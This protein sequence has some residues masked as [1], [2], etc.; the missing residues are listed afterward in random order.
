MSVAC[1]KSLSTVAVDNGRDRICR[2]ANM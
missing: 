1:Q 2:Y